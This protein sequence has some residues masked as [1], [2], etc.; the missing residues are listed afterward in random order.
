MKSAQFTTELSEEF[1][2][3]LD[4]L[5]EYEKPHRP[6][7]VTPDEVSAALLSVTVQHILYEFGNRGLDIDTSLNAVGA[8]IGAMLAIQADLAPPGEL[9]NTTAAILDAMTVLM[10]GVSKGV[11][12]VWEPK[13]TEH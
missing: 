10:Q 5:E 7:G 2:N 8:G 6:A 11:A 13:R 4:S 9:G 3:F 1:G 12:V